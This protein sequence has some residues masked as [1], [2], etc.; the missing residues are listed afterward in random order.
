VKFRCM[1]WG[2]ALHLPCLHKE[3][4]VQKLGHRPPP[5][6]QSSP[7]ILFGPLV[8]DGCM[9]AFDRYEYDMMPPIVLHAAAA[10]T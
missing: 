3:T 7:S 4:K 9:R 1:P 10:M 8:A 2:L 6:Q 5:P